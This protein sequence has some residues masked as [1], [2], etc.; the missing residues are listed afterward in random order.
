LTVVA[1]IGQAPCFSKEVRMPEKRYI[2]ELTPEERTQLTQLLR[3]G[4]GGARCNAR[5]RILL[6]AA[7][8]ATDA[9]VAAAVR[10]GVRTVER[11]RQKFVAGGVDWA[12]GERPRPGARRK[13]DGKQEA[14]L[15]ATACS[16]P[17][18]GRERWTLQLLADRLVEVGLVDSLS[19]ETVRRALQKTRPSRG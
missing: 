18:D 4:R 5:A 9:A 7:E 19:D 2:V 1:G 16:A 15:V 14:F 10:V 13:L 17:P 8:G 12:L 3:R 6:Q 11:T